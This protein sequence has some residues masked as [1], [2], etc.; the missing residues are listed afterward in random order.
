MWQTSRS[1]GGQAL[2]SPALFVP[3]VLVRC[4]SCWSTAGDDALSGSHAHGSCRHVRRGWTR[5]AV[6][7]SCAQVH[8]VFHVYTNCSEWSGCAV[9]DE[10]G[11]SSSR[12]TGGGQPLPVPR[13]RR[14]ELWAADSGVTCGGRSACPWGGQPTAWPRLVGDRCRRRSGRVARPSLA[15]PRLGQAPGRERSHT[16]LHART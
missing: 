12:W 2:E 3:T 11:E 8:R 14:C 7:A 5:W 1:E 10:P 9:L 15:Y 4:W 13:L 6:V 16:G